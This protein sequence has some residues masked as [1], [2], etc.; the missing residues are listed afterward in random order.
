MKIVNKLIDN[1]RINV[2]NVHIRYEDDV[3]FVVGSEKHIMGLGVTIDSL[4]IFPCDKSG[5][6]APVLEYTTASRRM[7]DIQNFS[8]YS[9]TKTENSEFIAGKQRL[10]ELVRTWLHPAFEVLIS[11][12]S[13]FSIPDSQGTH[14]RRARFIPP[15]SHQTYSHTRSPPTESRT[16]RRRSEYKCECFCRQDAI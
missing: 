8:V 16:P 10:L 12:I 15:V 9:N 5:N 4:S 13:Y 14:P 6:L 2:S 11:E 7:V 1:V 3:S